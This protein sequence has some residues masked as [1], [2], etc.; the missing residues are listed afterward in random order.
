MILAATD[1]TPTM[2]VRSAPQ[3]PQ[4]CKAAQRAL[5]KVAA[6]RSARVISDVIISTLRK[7]NAMHLLSYRKQRQS[8]IRHFFILARTP[9]RLAGCVMACATRTALIACVGVRQ[10]AAPP[11]QLTRRRAIALA[12]ITASADLQLTSTLLA[13]EQPTIVL[14]HRD[15]PVPRV[16]K[17]LGL[18]RN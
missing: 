1:L 6:R 8:V 15:I 5:A 10:R 7:L 9:T 14:V 3:G 18:G 16:D 4:A 13:V 11:L 2:L 12:A 17:S